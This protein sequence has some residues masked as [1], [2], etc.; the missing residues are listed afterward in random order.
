MSDAERIRRN[1]D[2]VNARIEAACRRA[3]R[4][5]ED[6]TLVAV[7]KTFPAAD[8]DHAIGAGATHLGE[9]RV[10]EAREKKPLVRGSAR[11]HLIGHLQSNKARDAVRLFDVI[12]SVDSVELAAKIARAAAS[13]GKTQEI[14][15]QVNVGREAQKSGADPDEAPAI[16]REI[17]SMPAL[18]LTGLM[19]IPPVGD[20]RPHFRALRALRDD[21][22]LEQLS[23]GMSADYEEAIEEGATL[24]R[25]GSAIFGARSP[26]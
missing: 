25:I 13:E 1:L 11:W 22:G 7:S 23:M 6:V 16:V 4:D 15:L 18:R 3:G 21:L 10:Q 2:D 24:V 9:N 12:E 19:T 8:V 14:L 20:S 5:R 26:R 17:A